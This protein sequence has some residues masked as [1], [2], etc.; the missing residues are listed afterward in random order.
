MEMPEQSDIMEPEQLT[1]SILVVDDEP[2]IRNVVSMFLSYN[3]LTVDTAADGEEALTG[4]RPASSRAQSGGSQGTEGES[5]GATERQPAAA[6]TRVR[7][8]KPVRFRFF[9][10][11]R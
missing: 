5:G 4:S 6:R 2:G 8:I 1:G 11:P 10:E 3:G 9:I 7:H